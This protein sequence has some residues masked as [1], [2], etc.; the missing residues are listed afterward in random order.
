MEPPMTHLT[1]G[2]LLL[3]SSLTQEVGAK[4]QPPRD[5]R[6]YF[7]YPT[8]AYLDKTATRTLMFSWDWDRV[9]LIANVRSEPGA[10]S[11]QIRQVEKVPV[12]LTAVAPRYYDSLYLVG[13]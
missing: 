12:F 4:H 1:L 2:M 6:R 3:L 7:C 8:G 9:E 5:L 10:P 11:R 13:V